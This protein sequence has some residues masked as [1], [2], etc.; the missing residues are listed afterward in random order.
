MLTEA[1]FALAGFAL[2]ISA[3]NVARLIP[4][5]RLRKQLEEDDE[6]EDAVTG[7]VLT[8]DEDAPMTDVYADIKR[9]VVQQTVDLKSKAKS[10]SPEVQQ[11]MEDLARSY[12]MSNR[13]YFT[14]RK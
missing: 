11:G 6:D 8:D 3:D 14:G 4:K 9:Y 12:L 10:D 1:L 2:G 7:D 5:L 13:R